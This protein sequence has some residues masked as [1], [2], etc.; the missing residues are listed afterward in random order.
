MCKFYPVVMDRF[1][2]CQCKIFADKVYTILVEILSFFLCVML[3][4]KFTSFHIK[5]SLQKVK[6]SKRKI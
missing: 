1:S 4:E 5:L 2:A 3:I 6:K